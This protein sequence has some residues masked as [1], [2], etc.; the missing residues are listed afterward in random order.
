MGLKPHK[1]KPYELDVESTCSSEAAIITDKLNTGPITAQS[2]GIRFVSCLGASSLLN[3]TLYLDQ[4][5]RARNKL[6]VYDKR[7]I[8]YKV[9]KNKAW[10]NT[11]PNLR[12][13]KT[14][15]NQ[16]EIFQ[17]QEDSFLAPVVPSPIVQWEMSLK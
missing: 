8:L 16:Q 9:N 5:K 17:S 1:I 3:T 13:I 11:L 10:I 12:K 6:K 15:M 14:Y 4:I 7:E 2:D